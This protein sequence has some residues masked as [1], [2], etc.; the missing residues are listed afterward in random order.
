MSFR[1]LLGLSIASLVGASASA[2]VIDFETTPGGGTPTDNQILNTPYNI[3]GGGTARFFFDFNGNNEFDSG[4]DKLPAFERAGTDT[5]SG[6]VYGATGQQDT[7]APGFTS[8]LGN[9]FLRTNSSLVLPFIIDYT[10]SQTI[11]EFAGQIW[12]ID[13]D[14][15]GTEQWRVEALNASNAVLSSVDSPIG[16]TPTGALDGRPWDFGFSIGSGIDKIRISFIGTKTTPPGLAF[17]NF[18]PVAIPEVSSFAMIG[19]A[20]AMAFGVARLRRRRV[21]DNG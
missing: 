14:A 15:S 21:T 4:V 7:A 11:T 10:T 3:D 20:G 18:N 12:D 6:F 9:F 8:Q 13:G 1:H 2:A 17:D 19:A 16:S 5:N